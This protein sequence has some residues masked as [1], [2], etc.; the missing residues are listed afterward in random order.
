MGTS[1]ITTAALSN[2]GTITSAIMP[3]T[4]SSGKGSRLRAE[5]EG[6]PDGMRPR[7]QSMNVYAEGTTS[8]DGQTSIEA[9]QAAERRKSVNERELDERKP[10][11]RL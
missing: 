5:S 8:G 1:P 10:H 7:G 9:A 2:A 4:N 6:N 11:T 3:V